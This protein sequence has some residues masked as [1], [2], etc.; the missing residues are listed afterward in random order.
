MVLELAVFTSNSVAELLQALGPDTKFLGNHLLRGVVREE[1]ERVEGCV[2]VRLLVDAPEDVVEQRLQVDGDC[3]FG[4]L[5]GSRE[6]YAV[7]RS[8]IGRLQGQRCRLL[9]SWTGVL[10]VGTA[11]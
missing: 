6:F 11:T 4:G 2:G 3:A 5:F 7:A 9:V 10:F 8:A 1:D